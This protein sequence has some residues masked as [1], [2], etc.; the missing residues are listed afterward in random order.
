MR[1]GGTA[2]A[3]PSVFFSAGDGRRPGQNGS[4]LFP[5]STSESIDSREASG[6]L[7]CPARAPYFGELLRL[8]HRSVPG[9]RER[10]RVDGKGRDPQD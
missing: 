3:G 9:G 6:T 4:P 8:L 10:R 7:H 1:T 5:G 2:S